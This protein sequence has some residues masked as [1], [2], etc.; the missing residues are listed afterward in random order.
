MEWLRTLRRRWIPADQAKR[1]S[2]TDG[3]LDK[4]G[5]NDRYVWRI[6]EDIKKSCAFASGELT[7]DRLLDEIKER[8]ASY[9]LRVWESCS[10][11]EKVVLG[12]V[13]QHG[14]VNAASRHVVRRLLVR[15]L[16]IKDPDTRLMN[17]TFRS[18]VLARDRVRLVTLLEGSAEASAWDR[19]RLPFALG[20]VAAA[21]FL[22][23]TQRDM[24]NQT[25]AAL[26]GVAAA[27]PTVA[28]VASVVARR[29]AG[30]SAPKPDA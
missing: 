12:H 1:R 24:F 6:C 4:E 15:R 23:A 25:V 3:V 11:D 9:Y 5:R 14:L 10:D 30:Q 29:D 27:V 19:L 7:R 8:T 13:A 18:F 2:E 17:S 21:A 28:R 16:L 22:F 26:A 20:A